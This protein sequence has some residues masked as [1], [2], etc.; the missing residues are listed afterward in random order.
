M[1]VYINLIYFIFFV[2]FLYKNLNYDYLVE[3]MN[4]GNLNMSYK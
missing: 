4:L 2:L 3:Y 1:Y